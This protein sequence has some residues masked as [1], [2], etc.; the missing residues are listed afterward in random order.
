MYPYG[1]ALVRRVVV[2][3]EILL[4][5]HPSVEWPYALAVGARSPMTSILT[6]WPGPYGPEAFIPLASA[7]TD[8]P[9]RK[10]TKVDQVREMNAV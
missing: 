2:G 1:R 4:D 7:A 8:E 6:Q 9:P 3:A 5:V 10:R